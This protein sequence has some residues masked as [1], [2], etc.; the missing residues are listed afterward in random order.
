MSSI[1]GLPNS[2]P[3]D[4][5]GV[6]NA[7]GGASV[8]ATTEPSGSDSTASVQAP[9]DA[10]TDGPVGVG[11]ASAG[12]S[13]LQVM[14]DPGAD[15]SS[16]S[17][18]LSAEMAAALQ[19]A[20]AAAAAGVGVGS[21]SGGASATG[22]DLHATQYDQNDYELGKNGCG[23]TSLAMAMSCFG[24]NVSP[25]ALMSQISV[26][27]DF[28][29]TAEELQNAAGSY[30]MDARIVNDSSQAQ[31]KSL[32]DSGVPVIVN[33]SS[34]GST[35]H[36]MLVSGYQED[37][38]GNITYT[39]NDPS[40]SAPRPELAAD[41]SAFMS[42]DFSGK[43]LEGSNNLIV[44]LAPVGSAA[45]AALPPNN[46]SDQMKAFAGA[47]SLVNGLSQ[48]FYP[49]DAHGKFIGWDAWLKKGI[50]Q[51]V[52]QIANGALEFGANVPAYLVDE[53]TNAIGG[54]LGK[55]LKDFAAIIIRPGQDL[56]NMGAD[57]NGI[58]NSLY[59]ANF[60]SMA[61]GVLK[62]GS[63]GVSLL[64]DGGK[65]V[66]SFLGDAWNDICSW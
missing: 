56:A 5:Q 26:T 57:A 14:P 15:N 37:A 13:A 50:E 43:S 24:V 41:L 46:E 32:L 59:H 17:S 8:S 3:L 52:F 6:G 29:T 63:D 35:G 10:Y 25:A 11:S 33:G 39:V 47:A 53:L 60:G 61:S 28:G 19:A 18:T 31:I 65:A 34:D 2:N 7:S 55:T 1:S 20:A 44:A 38:S 4:Y 36:W 45:E 58:W 42:S 66:V 12:A 62:L 22:V 40:S 54:N 23:P 49:Y 21:A 48:I 27:M 64:V 30:G 51:G 9:L 16:I